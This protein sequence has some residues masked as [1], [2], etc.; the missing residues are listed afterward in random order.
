MHPSSNKAL[1]FIDIHFASFRIWSIPHPSEADMDTNI[2]TSS[3]A[4]ETMN[5]VEF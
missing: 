5:A 3:W 2:L 4:I 1:N